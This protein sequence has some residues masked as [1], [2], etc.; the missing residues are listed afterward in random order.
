MSLKPEKI[1][2]T[3]KTEKSKNTKNLQKNEKK[4]ER[5]SFKLK[6]IKTEYSNCRISSYNDNS[7]TVE[8]MKAQD[9]NCFG[10]VDQKSELVFVILSNGNTAS[11]TT[12]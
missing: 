8:V 1:E 3:W 11:F 9:E 7:R 2:E 6:L 12:K 5:K 10:D 4:S